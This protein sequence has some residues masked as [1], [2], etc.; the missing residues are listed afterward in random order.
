MGSSK[1]LILFKQDCKGEVYLLG[2]WYESPW[3]QFMQFELVESKLATLLFC[4]LIS[5]ESSQTSRFA[6]ERL[7]KA[8]MYSGREYV[9]VCMCDRIYL[10]C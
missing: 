9:C 1:H 10:M 5:Q 6:Q 7:D 8:Q 2:D 4:I 3:G